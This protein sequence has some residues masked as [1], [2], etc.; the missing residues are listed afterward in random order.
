MDVGFKL[1]VTP[2]KILDGTRDFRSAIAINCANFIF[3]GN[4]VRQSMIEL[5]PGPS[6]LATL[7]R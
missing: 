5:V 4:E 7:S 1:F 3:V 6:M 2:S